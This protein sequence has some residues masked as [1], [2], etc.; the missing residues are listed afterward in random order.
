RRVRAPRSTGLARI[1][2]PA[3]GPWVARLRMLALEE[4]RAW[5]RLHGAPN[6][7]PRDMR[8]PAAPAGPLVEVPDARRAL[9]LPAEQ[10]DASVRVPLGLPRRAG[11]SS[12]QA[13]SLRSVPPTY[14]YR[15]G[16]GFRRVPIPA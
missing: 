14:R 4:I 11:D 7:H 16:R 15:F 10:R 1:G 6:G 9:G 13:G 8:G 3:L 5:N 12:Q 2:R